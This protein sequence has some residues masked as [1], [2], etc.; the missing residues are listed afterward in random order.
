MPEVFEVSPLSEAKKHPDFQVTPCYQ[1]DT[2]KLNFA[3][4]ES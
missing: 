2:T 3:Y 1:N 4:I